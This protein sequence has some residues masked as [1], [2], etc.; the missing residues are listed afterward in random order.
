MTAGRQ[1]AAAAMALLFALLAIQAAAALL[2]APTFVWND[3]RLARSVALRHGFSLYLDKDAT[4]PVIGTLHTPVSHF[5]YLLVTGFRNPS[6]ALI[7]GSLLSLLLSFVPLGW[8]LLRARA[9]LPDRLFMAT[10]AFLFCGFLIMQAP[11]TLHTASMIH[12]DAAAL[13]FATLACGVFCN[14][15]EP[16][17][18]GQAW[19]AGIFCVLA[20]GSK[21]TIAPI[22]PAL[23]LFVWVAAGA[24]RFVHFCAALLAGGIALLAIIV[25]LVPWRAFVFNTVTL[26]AHRPL[27]DGYLD[28]LVR[29]FREGKQDALPALF[30]MLLLVACHW[31]TAQRRRDV[32]AFFQANRWLAFALAAA[33]LVPVTAKAIVTVGADVNH[34]GMLLY[35]LFVAAG[36][37]IEQCLADP[38]RAFLRVIAWLCAV[39]G[40][41]VGIAPGL[42]ISL[43]ERLRD[44]H[45]NPSEVAWHYALRHPGRAYFPCNPLAGLLSDGKLYH[46]DFSLYDRDLAGYPLDARQFDAGLPSGFTIVAIPP[47]QKAWSSN[48]TSLLAHYRQVAEMELPG[49]TVYQRPPSPNQAQ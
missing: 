27:R 38:D 45:R 40:I 37:A 39:M 23:A 10:A 3:V 15:R 2:N 9:G 14:P 33:A 1:W 13:A 41:L 46:V 25:A 4:G 6:R 28:I 49:W 34:L 32:R 8:V 29:A 31:T 18:V 36:L 21:Q 19:L 35:L 7:A 20:V 26:A 48:L 11:G 22:V 30:P 42:L 5:L 47:G 24:K 44:L 16:V 43:P 17:T 12:V